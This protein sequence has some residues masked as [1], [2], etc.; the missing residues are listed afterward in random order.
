[1]LLV[2]SADAIPSAPGHFPPTPS[3]SKILWISILPLLS[4]L[5]AYGSQLVRKV[6]YRH[7]LARSYFSRIPEM[8]EQMK[9]KIKELPL[10]RPKER[11]IIARIRPD[12]QAQPSPDKQ[13][14]AA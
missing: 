11:E 1:M 4:L 12:A 7:V 9:G 13:L 5:Q 3:P 2:E 8:A 14:V 6:Q 10:P